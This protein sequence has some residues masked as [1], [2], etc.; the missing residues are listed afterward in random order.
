[1]VL[2]STNSDWSFFKKSVMKFLKYTKKEILK[3]QIYRSK[4]I[5][6]LEI[7]QKI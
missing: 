6:L 5:F 7:T 2:K 4:W 3:I 1:M